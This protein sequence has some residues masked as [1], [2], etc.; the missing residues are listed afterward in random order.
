M[1]MAVLGI[2]RTEE[3]SKPSAATGAVSGA[4]LGGTLGW[5]AGIG[6]LAI[7]A[8]GQFIA[9]GPIMAAI[10]ELAQVPLLAELQDLECQNTNPRRYEALI[11]GGGN[12]GFCTL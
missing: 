1:N 11:K 2:Y 10:E 4:I 7:P 9:A 12:S 8:I 5:L 6:K 3:A